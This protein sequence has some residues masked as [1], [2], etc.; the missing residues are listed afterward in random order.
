MTYDCSCDYG[1]APDFYSATKQ[2][3]RKKYLCEECGGPIL[4]GESYER[5]AAKWEIGIDVIRTCER[6]YDLRVW[7]KNNV[8]CLCIMHGNMDEEMHLAIES[9]YERARS[10]VTGL[11]FGF[12][13]RKIVRDRHNRIAHDVH[14]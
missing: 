5:V 8:P 2:R 1:D 7:V 10:E 11:W 14:A 3:A 6:C 13:R 9:A 12:Q 4:P